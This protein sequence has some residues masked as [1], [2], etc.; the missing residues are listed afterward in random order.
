MTPVTPR[1]MKVSV[2]GR[3]RVITISNQSDVVETVTDRVSAWRH[4]PQAYFESPLYFRQ[5]L[6][7]R[8]T[9][10][11][12]SYPIVHKLTKESAP[13]GTGEASGSGKPV[14]QRNPPRRLIR[15]RKET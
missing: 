10:W 8:P 3:V 2:A 4:M 13:L 7:K 11:G 14:C 12:I 1:K 15:E 6:P 5:W 9:C